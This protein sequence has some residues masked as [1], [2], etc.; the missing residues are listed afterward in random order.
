MSGHRLPAA[1]RV[2]V[3]ALLAGALVACE[4]RATPPIVDDDRHSRPGTLVIWADDDRVKALRPFAE[5]FA[6]RHGIH[7]EF[8]GAATADDRRY[9]FLAAVRAGKGPDLFLG[10]HSFTGEFVAAKA[11]V[12]IE[13]PEPVRAGFEPLS[14][15][16]GTYDGQ[17]YL[18]PHGFSSVV[19]YRDT[20]L[21]PEAPATIEDLVAAGR[22]VVT[23]GQ[24]SEILGLPVG[25]SGDLE[26]VYPLYTSAGGYLFAAKDDGTADPAQPALGTPASVAAFRRLAELG[27]TGSGALQRYLD[28]GKVSGTVAGGRVPMVA[29]HP[30]MME[31][32]R[33]LTQATWAASPVPGF[34]GGRPA[35]PLV[36]VQGFYL[37]SAAKNRDLAEQFLLEVAATVEV[38]HAL[39]AAW[40]MV[41]ALATAIDVVVRAD[42]DMLAVL[43]VARTGELVPSI[44]QM[45]KVW[46]PFGKAEAEVVG[47]GDPAK[48]VADAAASVGS[49]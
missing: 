9:D 38:Q 16:A 43:D 32:V 23:A 27:E 31:L 18:L 48:A 7:V 26:H 4:Q 8:D 22:R 1:A 49:G 37:S 6:A 46:T 2:V 19:L 12:P 29:L 34:A 33:P 24:A 42:P 47:G 40:P 35:R 17:L 30:F 21:V 15:R 39:Y 13:L 41:P 20:R 25:E 14:I 11:V 5:Q 36:R 10:E 45:R 3:A 44:P 28:L